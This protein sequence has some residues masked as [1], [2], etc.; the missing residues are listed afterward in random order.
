MTS[1]AD[2]LPKDRAAVPRKQGQKRAGDGKSTRQPVYGLNQVNDYPGGHQVEFDS[3]PGYERRRVHHPS[4]TYEEVTADGAK[5]EVVQGHS[6]VY[7]KG[8][9]TITVDQNHDVTVKGHSRMSIEGGM[10]VE[11]KGNCD[12]VV[13]GNM[14]EV[15]TGNKTSMIF[16]DHNTHVA[17]ASNLSAKTVTQYSGQSMSVKA[18]STLAAE[19]A[20]ETTMK[21][22]DMAITSGSIKHEGVS[23][24]KTHIHGEVVA[25]ADDTGPPAN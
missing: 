8:G 13:T 21:S 3:S 14:N 18:G 9:L 20:G 16:G 12:L 4:G 11:I 23:I 6:M 10:H 15:V 19:S 5:T 2:T 7:N 22:G 1:A 17:G 25:G 24:D